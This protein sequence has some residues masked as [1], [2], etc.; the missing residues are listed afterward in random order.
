MMRFRSTEYHGRIGQTIE[1]VLSEYSLNLIRADTNDF[2]VQ[3]WD[4][5]EACMNACDYGIAV[6]EQI[7]EH[8]I[9]PNVSLEL[10]YMRG[11]GKKCLIL[12]EQR[13]PALQTDLSG[14]LY[15]EFDVFQIDKTIEDQVR[16]WLRGIGMAK[17]SNERLL[18]FVSAGGTCR[19]ALAKAITEAFLEVHPPSYPLRVLATAMFEPS[20]SGA[21]EHARNAIKE[22]FGRD[23]LAGHRAM[24]LTPTLVGE[25]NLILVMDRAIYDVLETA[26]P[27]NS[28]NSGDSP[29][30]Y[31]LKPYFGLAGDIA[32]LLPHRDRSDA[33][34]LY[35]STAKELKSILEQHLD[36]VV[37][38]LDP[39]Q[40]GSVKHAQI[41][42]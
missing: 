30:V 20:L 35:L 24:R 23:L 27:P 26:G 33:N 8:D 21:S 16:R 28:L 9:N 5:V 1:R 25:A 40:D 29:K 42:K 18:V 12:K 34:E 17:K 2:A 11:Q 7:D 6:F 32:D 22:L 15:S 31:V 4:N 39:R 10:G 38:A 14:Y 13:L 37:K 3:L 36:D 19:C 41:A